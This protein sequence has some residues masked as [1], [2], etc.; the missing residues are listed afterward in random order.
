[1]V[2]LDERRCHAEAHGN[3]KQFVAA[4]APPAGEQLA[5]VGLVLGRARVAVVPRTVVAEEIVRHEDY[6]QTALV[7]APA[8]HDVLAETPLLAQGRF[9]AAQVAAL[10]DADRFCGHRKSPA[11]ER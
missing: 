5:D 6:Q 1:M 4:L 10:D 3:R 2:Q 8:Q 7:P 11:G 9:Q